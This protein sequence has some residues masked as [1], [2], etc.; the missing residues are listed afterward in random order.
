MSI[1]GKKETLLDEEGQNVLSLVEGGFP[2]CDEEIV[3]KSSRET[4]F[5]HP[6]F[7]L[8]QKLPVVTDDEVKE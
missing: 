5:D 3:E 8:P 1:F 6:L 2:Q 4:V 7:Q